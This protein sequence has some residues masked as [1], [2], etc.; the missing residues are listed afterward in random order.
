MQAQTTSIPETSPASG[1]RVVHT[2]RGPVEYAEVGAGP[3]V[4]CLHGAMGGYDQSL[5]L[6][7]SAGAPGFRYLAVSRPGYLGTPLASGR[8]PAEQADLCAALLDEVGERQAFVM[9]VS[10]G[11]PAAVAFALRHPDRCRGLV[12]VS[13][14]TARLD[15]PL[16]LAWHL[17]K[18]LARVPWL[19]KALAPDPDADPDRATRRSIRDPAVRARTLG[20]PEAGPLL[21][22][23]QRSTGD[24]LA[25][26][27]PGTENDI[28]VTR[29]DLGLALE[30]IRCPVL[31]IHGTADAVVPFAQARALADRV[32]GAELFA[33]EGG[34]HVTLFTHLAEVRTRVARFLG[35]SG[36]G[37]AA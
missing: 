20:D 10:G 30:T 34:E 13:A 21:L 7:R 6:A 31:A 1:P 8:A 12:L 9:A 18:L 22:S 2:R 19:A 11:G 37:G 24:R 3:A 5:L 29:Q 36:V 25:A 17:L 28:A 27:L 15:T 33:A 26:R 32:P 16:P 23:L 35:A 14:C 4:L